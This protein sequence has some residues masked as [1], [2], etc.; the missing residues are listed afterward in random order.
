[1]ER[2]QDVND[3]QLILRL[4]NGETEIED[5]LLEKYKP[6]VRKKANAMFLIGGETE[7]LIQEGMIGL[8]KAVRDYNQ[9]RASA[10]FHFAELCITRQMYSA[11]EASNRKKHGPLNSYVS[12]SAEVSDGGTELSELFMAPEADNPEHLV[13][14]SETYRDLKRKLF[15]RLSRMEHQVLCLYMEGKT[16]T[17]IAEMMERSPKSVDNALGRV[18]GKIRELAKE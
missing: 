4:R 7:D 2:Y 10:F 16:Y 9:E 15:A 12:L 18:R 8:F 17:E 11:V 6:L 13:I 3:E 1:M 5:Y 14:E